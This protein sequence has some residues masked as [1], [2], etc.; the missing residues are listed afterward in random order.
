MEHCSLARLVSHEGKLGLLFPSRDD[1]FMDL[2]V[3]ESP[4]TRV[5]KNRNRIYTEEM[6]HPAGDLLP[7]YGTKVA[8]V[9]GYHEV[10]LCLFSPPTMNV[11]K[12]KHV[13]TSEV[14]PYCSDLVPSNAFGSATTRQ[15]A[16]M[17]STRK[18]YAYRMILK[19]AHLLI[20]MGPWL[21]SF[22][23]RGGLTGCH[24]LGEVAG[25]YSRGYCR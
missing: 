2:W 1:K 3:M 25:D 15:I 9:E 7:L 16:Q 8:L 17:M 21:R 19:L 10:V 4:Q 13:I 11:F 12:T 22:L 23:Q 5:W 14:F 24:T 6:G 18:P 20:L